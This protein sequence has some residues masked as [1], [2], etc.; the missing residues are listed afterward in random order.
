MGKYRCVICGYNGDEL[1]YQ[2]NEYGYC[3]ASNEE[4][5]EFIGNCPTWVEKEGFGEAEIGEPVGCP[6]CHAWGVDKFQLV[7]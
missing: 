2:F 6:E 1:I 4:D 7:E 5:P 3:L